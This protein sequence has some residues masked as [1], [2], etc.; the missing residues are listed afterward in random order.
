[1]DL[2]KAEYELMFRQSPPPM[3]IH[4]L[5]LKEDEVSVT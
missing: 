2:G 4:D 3:W 5:P 1:M